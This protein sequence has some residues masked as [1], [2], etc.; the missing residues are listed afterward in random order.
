M[1]PAG[2]FEEV[3]HGA[4][5]DTDQEIGGMQERPVQ[6]PL[7]GGGGLPRPLIDSVGWLSNLRNNR[8]PTLVSFGRR[9][10]L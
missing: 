9:S 10:N 6:G 5:K 4:S 3:E 7:R 8:S 1:S 2:S